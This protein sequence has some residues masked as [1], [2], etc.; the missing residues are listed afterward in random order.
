VVIIASSGNYSES[1]PRYPAR[2]EE[3][4]ATGA[5]TYDEKLASYSNRGN[6]LCAP[7]GIDKQDLNN[8]GYDDMVLQNTFNPNTK[9]VCDLWYWFFAGTSMAAPHVSGLVAL[10]LSVDSTLTKEAVRQIL[11]DTA[12]TIEPACGY[13]LI[14]AHEALRTVAN[15]DNP[16]FVNIKYPPDGKFVSGIIT[17][18]INATDDNDTPDELT[19]EWNVDGGGGVWK[20]TTYNSDTELYESEEWD[21]GEVIDGQHFINVRATDS[22]GNET[23]VSNSVLVNNYNDP[24]VVSFT[25]TCSGLTCVFDASESYDPDGTIQS[26]NW[27]FGGEGTQSEPGSGAT[28]SY[29]YADAGTYTVSLTVTDDGGATNSYSEDIPVTE[30]PPTVHIGDLEA[31]SRNRRW[32]IWKATITFTVHDNLH[33]PVGG[34]KVYGVFSDGSSVFECS[35][36]SKGICSVSGWQL[37]LDCLTYTVFDISHPDYLYDPTIDRNHDADGDSDGTNITVCRPEL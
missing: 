31:S 4:I 35:T 13:G 21:T 5:T 11:R 23:T 37:W 29:T 7:G 6:E 15:S 33:D 16:P 18:N 14:N 24:P 28:V 34:A 32:G 8:D 27:S 9:D 10:M 30:G 3:V 26:Y 19:V 17:V 20:P 22:S 25:Y 36:D 1:T 2:Y 12:D